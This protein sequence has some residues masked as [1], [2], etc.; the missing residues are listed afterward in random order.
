MDL[1]TSAV[2]LIVSLTLYLYWYVKKT[3]SFFE[4]HG[5]PF[6]KPNLFFGNITDVILLRKSIAEEC[7]ELYKQLEPHRLAGI[8]A[9]TKPIIMIRDPDL[10]KDILIKDFANFSD[11]GWKV[12]ETVE[13]LSNHVFT[14]QSE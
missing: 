14:M 2:L 1:C 3:Y 7:A 9:G 13:P 10:L 4:Q 11:R 6:I 12:D 5:I 8:F